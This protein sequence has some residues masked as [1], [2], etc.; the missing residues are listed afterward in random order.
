MFANAL[1]NQN[2]LPS[3][4][5]EGLLTEKLG[6][7]YLNSPTSTSLT[8]PTD[9]PI[10][11]YQNQLN[12]DML[13]Q[14]FQPFIVR[15]CKTGIAVA[16]AVV[17][18]TD[19]FGWIKWAEV[20]AGVTIVGVVEIAKIIK[21]LAEYRIKI[22]IQK[23]EDQ[24][25]QPAPPAP[26]PE[27]PDPVPESAEASIFNPDENDQVSTEVAP[28]DDEMPSSPQIEPL[29]M[30]VLVDANGYLVRADGERFLRDGQPIEFSS[31]T[32]E[33][34]KELAFQ[35]TGESDLVFNPQQEINDVE[36]EVNEDI[37]P[38]ETEDFPTVDPLPDT[39]P[40]ET[41]KKLRE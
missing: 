21:K 36:Q 14:K 6:N 27:D 16:E 26:T 15:A 41:S 10:T 7:L 33:Q 1:V 17:V 37:P 34:K 29:Q 12:D 5:R 18:L 2:G 38:E 20:L 22:E 25:T 24:Q 40:E 35:A 32:D 13:N 19:M 9:V 4:N 8:F 30:V 31:L 23:K 11:E 3:V 28:P 39:P